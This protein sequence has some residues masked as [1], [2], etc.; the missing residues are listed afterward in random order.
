MKFTTS[1]FIFLL[2]LLGSM[3]MHASDTLKVKKIRFFIEPKAIFYIPV[4]KTATDSWKGT[5]ISELPGS[6][7][8]D[9][10]ALTKI[11]NYTTLNFGLAAGMSVKLN[12]HLYY[13]LALTY[14]HFY[15]SAKSTN[16]S[17]DSSGNTISNITY[18]QKNITDVL[19]LSNG[20]SL[21]IKN[22]VFTNSVTLGVIVHKNQQITT[23][24]EVSNQA[25]GCVDDYET[26]VFPML[27][28]KI[29]YSFLNGR[30]EPFVGINFAPLHPLYF[31]SSTFPL[32]LFS[33]VKISF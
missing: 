31:Q 2:M 15:Q 21:R 22:F 4:Q 23:Q 1:R 27:E 26:R 30:I 19:G 14:Y 13:E 18:T 10:T 16:R 6:Y 5:M 11:Q 3:Y 8:G 20:L 29:G 9:Y 33:S 25:C 12:K 17:N 32:M 7:S 24:P 28:S